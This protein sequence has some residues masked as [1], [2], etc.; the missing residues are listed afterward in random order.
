MSDDAEVTM[1]LFK[2]ILP[3][4]KHFLKQMED[5]IIKV[6]LANSITIRPIWIGSTES[7]GRIVR[8]ILQAQPEPKILLE[9]LG[10][11]L[12]TL[13]TDEVLSLLNKRIGKTQ[14]SEN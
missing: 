5:T 11:E 2:N 1:I 8:L 9:F 14:D 6:L 7:G 3:E 4:E 12:Q 10:S 13:S